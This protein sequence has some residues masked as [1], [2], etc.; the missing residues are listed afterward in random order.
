MVN[1]QAVSNTKSMP[2]KQAVSNTQS[3]AIHNTVLFA[4][5][6]LLSACSEQHQTTAAEKVAAEKVATEKSAKDSEIRVVRVKELQLKRMLEI[7]GELRA[8]QN[9]AIEAKVQGYVSSINVDRGSKLKKGDEILTI[10]CPE[11]LEHEKE[12]EAKYSSAVSALRK[13][14]A[15]LE[16]AK[17]KLLEAKARLDA[18]S[19]TLD[20]LN[21]TSTKMPGAVAQ[22]DIDVQMKTVESDKARVANM[23]SEVQ[24]SA[25]VIASDESNVSA[26]MNVVK[27]VRSL[28][29]YLRIKAPFDGVISERNVHNGSMVGP[30]ENKDTPLVR[31]QQRNLLRLVVALPEDAV[32]GLKAG[33]RIAFQ[34]PAF[35]GTPF[36][37]TVARPA[38]AI[39]MST[40]TMPV[41]ASVPNEDGRLEPGMFATVQWPVSR[42]TKTLFVPSS[43]VATNLSGTFV[44]VIK[45]GVARQSKVQKGQPMGDL[46]EV[47]GDVKNNDLV[48]VKATDEIKTGTHLTSRV[49]DEN[50]STKN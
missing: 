19:L 43:A 41:E 36:Y 25:A 21:Q 33:Q 6:L 32:A 23:T 48:A 29:S 42:P 24:A 10:F 26:A 18:D 1:K 12:E 9:V 22:N 2:Y 40:R 37:G 5:T 27:S 4:I 31:I 49:T 47:V 11:L 35:L 17:S 45:N 7:P 16:S 28:K 15:A 34:V 8:F 44:D 3:V 50:A 14:Q 38:Y 39:D 30:Q 13:G 46:V 20:R